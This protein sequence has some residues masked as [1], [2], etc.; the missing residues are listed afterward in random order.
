MHSCQGLE[1]PQASWRVRVVRNT[2]PR[3]PGLGEGGGWK[4]DQATFP[5]LSPPIYKQRPPS[6]PE[7]SLRLTL[8]VTACLDVG[9]P[10]PGRLCS[11]GL[12]KGLLNP[13]AR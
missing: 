10:W 8:G 12:M 7:G 13:C 3:P 6:P 9:S 11:P 5:C 2:P 1:R 4:E